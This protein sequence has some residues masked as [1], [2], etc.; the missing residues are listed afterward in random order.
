MFKDVMK[1][2]ESQDLDLYVED[3]HGIFGDYVRYLHWP[4]GQCGGNYSCL[5]SFQTRI[6]SKRSKDFLI[7]YKIFGAQLIF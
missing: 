7:F 3:S 6:L 5:K 1:E 4:L 2:F